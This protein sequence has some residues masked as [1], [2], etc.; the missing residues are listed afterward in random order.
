MKT[1]SISIPTYNRSKLVCAQVTRLLPQLTDE[2]ELMV[3]DNASPDDT[4]PKLGRI[5]EKHVTIKPSRVNIG[6]AGNICRAL[7]ESDAEWV[8]VLGDDDTVRPNAIGDALK[9]C[10][11]AKSGVIE[12]HS[13]GGTIVENRIL[14]GLEDMFSFHDPI[15]TLFISSHIFHKPSVSR[16]LSILAPSC[17]TFGPHTALILRMLE[18]NSAPLS[19]L[20]ESL[21]VPEKTV[22]GWSSMEVALGLSLLPE[23]IQSPHF[24]NI[25]AERLFIDTCWMLSFGLREVVDSESATK[26]KRVSKQVHQNLQAYGAGHLPCGDASRRPRKKEIL[27]FLVA[28]AARVLPRSALITLGGRLRRK[29]HHDRGAALKDF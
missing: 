12:F 11:A 3:F 20:K 10:S 1:L 8:W 28:R 21:L 9:F 5:S 14:H 6:M 2:C 17:F 24:Q 23:F 29:Y 22:K 13:T 25:A 16:H 18:A 27:D 4:L 19:L 7:I 15:N 26:W